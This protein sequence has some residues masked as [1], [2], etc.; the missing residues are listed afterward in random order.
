M[1]SS[2]PCRRRCGRLQLLLLVSSSSRVETSSPPSLRAIFV[3]NQDPVDVDA[4]DAGCWSTLVLVV[5]VCSNECH[6]CHQCRQCDHS[7]RLLARH[8]QHRA[9]RAHAV[10]A[11]PRH[12][13]H[14]TTIALRVCTCVCS[15]ISERLAA[16][17]TPKAQ[18]AQERETHER[19]DPTNERARCSLCCA[20]SASSVQLKSSPLVCLTR[21]ASLPRLN[22]LALVVCAPMPTLGGTRACDMPL[23]SVH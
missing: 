16:H 6:H 8:T 13:Y 22:A 12:D 3:T 7:Y 20:S 11:P 4:V 2:Y 18:E 23:I 14:Y 9:L 5:V 1:A 21:L 15:I 19:V 10:A 17:A